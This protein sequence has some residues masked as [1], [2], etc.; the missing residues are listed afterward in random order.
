MNIEGLTEK[1]TKGRWKTVYYESR[2]DE[3]VAKVCRKCGEVSPLVSYSRDKAGLGGRRPHCK[4]CEKKIGQIKYDENKEYKLKQ[5]QVYYKKNK[6]LKLKYN[7]I[8]Y[9][10]NKEKCLENVRIWGEA[11]KQ[12]VSDNNRAWREKN[13]ERKL[14]TG[15]TWREN[16]R[17]KKQIAEQ[18]RR[19]RKAMLLDTLTS[20][21]YEE[22]VKRLG[23]CALTGETNNLTLDHAIP[24][25]V[26][27]GGTTKE[28]CYPLRG[29]LNSSKCDRNIF[30]W[31]EANRQRFELSQERFDKLI[32][33]LASANAMTVE[34]Y[35]AYV[36]E[37]H[38]N[39]RSIDEIKTEAV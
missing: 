1:T 35:R 11:N 22:S 24:I 13:K 29:D 15:R 31:F 2:A 27:H 34:E 25:A 10:D 17:D 9:R 32:E 7:K 4:I 39:P 14:M 19:A 26:G 20:K 37:C 23:G 33:W 6:E 38:A 3:I 8:Y 28:N 21:E 5:A 16:N 12:R 18:R 30:E 36:Y